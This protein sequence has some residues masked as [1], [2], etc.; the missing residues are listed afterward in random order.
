LSRYFLDEKDIQ[1]VSPL[2]EKKYI[3]Y[4]DSEFLERVGLGQLAPRLQEFWL[5]RGPC[6]DVLAQIEGGC[7]LV[8]AKSHMPEIYGGDPGRET[9][10]T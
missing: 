3:E 6:W 2:A 5:Q 1:W 4:R 8:E 10:I 9:I 7:L